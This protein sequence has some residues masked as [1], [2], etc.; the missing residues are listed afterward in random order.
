[1]ASCPCADTA[2]RRVVHD[3]VAQTIVIST[4]ATFHIRSV[5]V[6]FILPRL[7]LPDPTL[8]RANGFSS[9]PVGP[10]RRRFGTGLKLPVNFHYAWEKPRPDLTLSNRVD[11]APSEFR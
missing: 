6:L 2:A 1:M 10:A 9:Q 11:P 5:P 4:M 8:E 7:R 3:T